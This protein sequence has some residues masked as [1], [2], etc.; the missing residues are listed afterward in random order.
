MGPFEF[1]QDHSQADA[2][3][4]SL[5]QFFPVRLI[6]FVP[7]GQGRVIGMKEHAF[8]PNCLSMT[9]DE[10]YAGAG[11]MPYLRS[12]GTAVIGCHKHSATSL[13]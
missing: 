12:L 4:D 13:K 5:L 2:L 11:P 10:Q 3:P 6:V 9:I 7:Q 1:E 8:Q